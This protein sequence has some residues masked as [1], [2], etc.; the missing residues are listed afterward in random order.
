MASKSSESQIRANKEQNKKR[1]G[2]SYYS[3]VLLDNETQK[4]WLY[5]LTEKHG[6]TRKEAL[7]KAFS[8]LEKDLNQKKT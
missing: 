4:V 7:I 2:S 5:S 6:G 8:L 3:A 1:K